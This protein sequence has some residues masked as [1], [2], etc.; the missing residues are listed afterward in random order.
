MNNIYDD[1]RF[2]LLTAQI[3]WPAIG[4]T[5]SAWA[6]AP[7]FDPTDST[8]ADIKARGAVELGVSLPVLGTAVASNGTAQTGPVVI[9]AVPIGPNVTW[10]TMARTNA[11]HDLSSLL[12]FVDDAMGLPFVPDGLDMLVQPDWALRR[13]WFRP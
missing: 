7:D 5:L 10:F 13:G 9:P 3:N 1:A 11:A 2:A 8:I 4:L 6:G 12:L